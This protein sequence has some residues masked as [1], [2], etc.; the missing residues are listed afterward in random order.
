MG[1]LSAEMLAEFQKPN[2]AVVPISSIGFASG[3]KRYA[4][5]HVNVTGVGPYEGRITRWGSP[6]VR[7]ISDRD[8]N[9]ATPQTSIF[10]SDADDTLAPLLEG[11]DPR[12]SQALITLTSPNVALAKWWTPFN[13]M[14]GFWRMASPTVF[15]LG[16]QFRDQPLRGRVNRTAFMS[17]DWPNAD[18]AIYGKFAPIVYGI[19]DSTNSTQAGMLPTYLVDKGGGT[20][21]EYAGAHGWLQSVDRVF[22]NGSIITSGVG[23]WTFTIN[24][25]VKNGRQWTTVKF[26]AVAG[27]YSATTPI[28]IDVHGYETV[29]DGTGS[30]IQASDQLQHFLEQ[31]CFRDY[32]GGNWAPMG[33]YTS[34]SAF[35]IAKSYC[36]QLGILTSRCY[37]GDTQTTGMDAI[38]EFLRTTRLFAF[39]TTDGLIGLL[40][41]DPR[42]PIVYYDEPQWVAEH[43]GESLGQFNVD[44]NRDSLIDR[45]NLKYL[46]S[47]AGF[48]FQRQMEIRDLLLSENV[49]EALEM[50]WAQSA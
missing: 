38:A 4:G 2:P 42:D 27:G 49:A 34:S 1:L 18:S 17:S 19:H 41:N 5:T 25:P 8:G 46:Y 44:F 26:S 28:T 3:T 16:F 37:G 15:E 13:G 9:L 33:T 23:G 14:L 43:R 32:Q 40:P 22:Y 10:I 36:S 39:W 12:G 21:P 20:T 30:M 31:W 29:G 35:A 24:H 50:P 7:A 45:I 47:T 11:Q 6:F 48:G